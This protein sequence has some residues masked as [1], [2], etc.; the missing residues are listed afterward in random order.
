[1][2]GIGGAIG[3]GL[4]WA[5]ARGCARPGR[6]WRSFTPV[7]QHAFE[8]V[9]NLAALAVLGIWAMIVLCQLR[10]VSW[11]KAGRVRRPSFRM[12]RS[13]WIGYLTLA[14]LAGVLVL[15]ALDH[16]V[17]TFTIASLVV[18]V[19]ALVAGWFAVRPRVQASADERA[20][21]PGEDW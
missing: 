9:L 6:F 10:F 11:S 13:P 14:F 18:I 2:I 21:G 1:M 19:P 5:R 12:P 16:P 7:P 8:I 20:G 15:M 3:T 4:F 17:G